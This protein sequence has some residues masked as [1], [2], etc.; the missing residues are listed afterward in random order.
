VGT[1]GWL[2]HVDAPNLLFFNLRPAP[3]HA[4]GIVARFLECSNHW[5]QATIRCV[6]DP[7]RASLIDARGNALNTCSVN[8][9][10]VSFE[11]PAGDLSQLKVDFSEAD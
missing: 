9:D 4:D 1:T 3:D 5:V 10:S 7:H 2:F 11:M 8:G 6:R